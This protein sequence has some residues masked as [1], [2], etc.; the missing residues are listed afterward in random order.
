MTPFF[1]N[2]LVLYRVISLTVHGLIFTKVYRVHVRFRKLT[3]LFTDA[4][5][6]SLILD[7]CPS[8]VDI[9]SSQ[10]V[11]R[12]SLTIHIIFMSEI[13]MKISFLERQKSRVKF[14]QS[15]S[16][17]ILNVVYTVAVGEIPTIGT[18]LNINDL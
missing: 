17:A 18:T 14:I 16:V 8:K 11:Q 13:N 3:L 1:H 15:R 6:D 7:Q 4:G 2:K 10:Y 12:Y 5:V 9:I